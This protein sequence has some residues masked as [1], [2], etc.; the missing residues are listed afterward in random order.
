MK[1]EVEEF[2]D[3]CQEVARKM[4]AANP[5]IKSHEVFSS[6]AF[7]LWRERVM[8]V[9]NGTIDECATR[10]AIHSQYP[11]TTDFDR[12]YDRGRQDAAKAIRALK[13]PQRD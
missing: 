7:G 5:A 8:P 12:G 9:R 2:A 10:A 3:F 11:I 13:E 4:K 6:I 1:N